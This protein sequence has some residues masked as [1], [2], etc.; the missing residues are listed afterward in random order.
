MKASMRPKLSEHLSKAKEL[1]KR[2]DIDSL[3]YACLEL[4]FAIEFLT[5]D[6]LKSYLDQLPYDILKVWQPGKV[7]KA[8]AEIDSH[9][10]RDCTLTMYQEDKDGN[11]V[12][13][14]MVGNHNS[15]SAKWATKAYSS[16][17]SFLH[18][19]TL[20]KVASGEDQVEKMTKKLTDVIQEIERV[21]AGSIHNL[22]LQNY[23]RFTCQN[24]CGATIKRCADSLP[25]NGEVKC[26]NPDCKAVHIVEKLPNKKFRWSLRTATWKCDECGAEHIMEFHN[27][28]LP[29]EL[30]CPD[31]GTIWVLHSTLALAKKEDWDAAKALQD[32]LL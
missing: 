22:V 29:E 28:R 27:P 2:G 11:P 24:E 18:A 13:P 20:N 4:R 21:M 9:V 16:L 26:P 15:F 7:I 32:I 25:E 19:P 17:G 6:K 30:N 31:C 3:R 8:L 23:I 1:L 12:K 14:V 5:Y 10:E